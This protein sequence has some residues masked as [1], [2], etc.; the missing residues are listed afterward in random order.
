MLYHDRL[1]GTYNHLDMGR[2][3]TV[4]EVLGGEQVGS[5]D[6]HGTQLMQSH[7]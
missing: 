4:D 5:G 7:D 6:G 3:G 1:I 2:I